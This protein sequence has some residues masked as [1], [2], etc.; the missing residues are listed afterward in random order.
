M[1]NTPQI[2][3]TDVHHTAVIRVI[4]PC[5]QIH[6]VMGP[7]MSE[8][9]A[10]VAAQGATR[11]G[12]LFSHHF[13]TVPDVFDLEVGVPVLTPVAAAGRVVAST[14]PA[15]TVA[16]T[17]YHGGYH[18][19]GAAWGEFDAWLKASSH[20]TADDLWECYVSGPESSADPAEWRTELIRPLRG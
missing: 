19:L 20:P 15:T 2:V 1:I 14:R 12:P 11:N 7:A 16:R 6:H 9:L 8:V 10:A 5:D 3:Q 18:G 4:V 17:V 13:R